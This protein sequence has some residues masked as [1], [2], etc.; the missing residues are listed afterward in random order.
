MVHRGMIG[1]RVIDTEGIELGVVSKVEE[2][3]VEVSEGL[4]D[5]LLLNKTYIGKEEEEEVILKDKIH[6]LLEGMQ[7]DGSDGERI[8]I[9]KET[10]YAGDILDT[11]IIETDDKNLF[12]ITLEEIF[13]IDK[14]MT[15]DI[16]LETVKKDGRLEG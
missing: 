2:N 1:K 11:L 4:F 14:K 15:L 5:E 3:T 7:V 8:G 13:K 16:D 9:V 10:I 6:N 12:F